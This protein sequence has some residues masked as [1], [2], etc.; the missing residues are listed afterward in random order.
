MPEDAPSDSTPKK[1]AV[2]LHNEAQQDNEVPFAILASVLNDMQQAFYLLALQHERRDVRERARIPAEIEKRYVLR[3]AIPNEGSYAQPAVLGDPHSELFASGDL[4]AVYSGFREFSLAIATSDFGKLETIVPDRQMRRRILDRFRSMIPKPG[5][6]WE[7]RLRYGREYTIELGRS[8]YNAVAGLLKRAGRD[9]ITTNVVTG[10]LVAIDFDAH[11]ITMKY[12]PT[13]REFVCYYDESIE[14]RLIDQ[15]R[16]LIQ[17]TGSVTLDED[18]SPKKITDVVDIVGVDLSP[19]ILSEFESGDRALR[20]RHP[21]EITPTLDDSQQVFCLEY[22]PLGIDMYAS[23]REELEVLIYEEL[24][25]LWRN[26][27]IEDPRHL[28]LD[29]QEL[30][31]ELLAAIEEIDNAT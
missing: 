19:F 27:A 14:E 16:E 20:F 1:F 7:L 9:A 3:A 12:P 18:D 13:R 15:R 30:Q 2:E 10:K 21:L 8:A 22:E 31:T 28:S 29:A 5:T 11:E 4:D 23:T 6:G 26:Y 17:I 25:V 24:D